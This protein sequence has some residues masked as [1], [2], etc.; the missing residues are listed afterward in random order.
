MRTKTA[1]AILFLPLCLVLPRTGF[2]QESPASSFQA[3]GVEGSV[4]IYDYKKDEWHFTDRTDAEKETLPAST[5]KIINSAIALETGAVENEKEIIRWDGEEKSF[6]GKRIEAWNKDSDLASAYRNST[7][8][9]YVEL[10]RRIGKEKYRDFLKR[11]RYGNMDLS[12]EGDDFWNK[13]AFGVSPVNQIE[14]L[15]ALHEE[16]L[17][18]SKETFRTVKRLMISEETPAYVLR[19]KT[20]WTKAGGLDIGWWTGYVERED[21]VYFFA[22]RLTQ[23]ADVPN[24]RFS[25]C[26]KSIARAALKQTGA[27]G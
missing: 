26:R 21:N 19:D 16:T 8:W 22:A 17:P 4:T 2:P 27:F 13:G 14:F 23:R 1:A 12:E 11:S 7:V 5:F 25:D 10:A 15:K 6:F 20:G 9:F 18:F 24:S 3:C